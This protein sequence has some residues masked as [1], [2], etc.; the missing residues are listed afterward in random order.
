MRVRATGRLAAALLAVAA[1]CS[2]APA[3]D[4]PTPARPATVAVV[5]CRTAFE[6]LA[7][8]MRRLPSLEAAGAEL[9]ATYLMCGSIGMWR[10]VASDFLALASL[11]PTEV[12]RHLAS[13][14]TASETLAGVPIC[15]ELG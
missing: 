2:C 8:E 12:R 1:L 6:G 13:R 5:D 3:D 7:G 15:D 14:C 11:D 4:V 9:D 10:E